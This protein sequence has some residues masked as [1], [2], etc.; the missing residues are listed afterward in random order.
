MRDVAD[1]PVTQFVIL[2]LTAMAFIIL[3]KAAVSYLPDGSI[4]GAVKKVVSI[5]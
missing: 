4:S 1:H 2:G 5:A 3:V